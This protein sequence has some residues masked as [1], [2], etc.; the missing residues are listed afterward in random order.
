MLYEILC[1]NY[2]N[3][4]SSMINFMQVILTTSHTFLL[5]YSLPL[6]FKTQPQVNNKVSYTNIISLCIDII[7]QRN[8]ATSMERGCVST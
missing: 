5:A 2:F 6:V 3:L 4:H 1:I 8:H 7:S